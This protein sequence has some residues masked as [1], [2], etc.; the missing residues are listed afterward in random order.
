MD[1]APEEKEVRRLRHDMMNQVH[2]IVGN[3]SLLEDEVD[4]DA[5]E[6]VRDANRAATELQA[7][8]KELFTKLG[9]VKPPA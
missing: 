6:M 7:Q 4:G 9:I 5:A 3:L 2:I 8:M 1:P